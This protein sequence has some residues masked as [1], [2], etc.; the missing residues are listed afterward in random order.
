MKE[1]NTIKFNNKSRVTVSHVCDM[2]LG[3]AQLNFLND[4]CSQRDLLHL[5][6]KSGQYE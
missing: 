1:T 3:M 6:I 5:N 4:A 2:F